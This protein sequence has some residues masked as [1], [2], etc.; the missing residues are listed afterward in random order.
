M[1]APDTPV[2]Q[3]A[4]L[5]AEVREAFNSGISRP[6]EF[7]RSQLKSLLHFLDEKKEDIN[8]AMKH[9]LG[10]HE[11]ESVLGEIVPGMKAIL[12]KYTFKKEF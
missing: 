1:T 2:D 8:A 6:L 7:R 3:I 9:D 4:G 5:V 10:R 12:K 11:Q